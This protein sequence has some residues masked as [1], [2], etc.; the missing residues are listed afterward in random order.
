MS[1]PS[2]W[3]WG[4]LP[5]AVL[6]LLAIFFKTSVVEEDVQARTGAAVAASELAVQVAGRDVTL[7]GAMLTTE[8][9]DVAEATHGVRLVRGGAHQVATADAYDWSLRRDG[10]AI[11]LSGQVPSA[12]ARERITAAARAAFPGAE[13]RD[14]TVVAADAPSGFEEA[15]IH[16][17]GQAARLSDGRA[18]LSGG[19]YSLAGTAPTPAAYEA[20]LAATPDLPEGWTLASIDVL[21]IGRAHV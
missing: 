2:K 6:W 9:R 10:G 16:A 8:M 20:V 21:Q 17:V 18:S 1:R 14:E 19:Q 11:V 15:A 3:W 7:E 12:P 5:L 13:I 4:L